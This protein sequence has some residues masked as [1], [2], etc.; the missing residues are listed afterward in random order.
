MIIE[1][2][3]PKDILALLLPVM[4]PLLQFAELLTVRT[5]EPL[6]NKVPPVIVRLP[7]DRL[8]ETV[9]VPLEMET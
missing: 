2:L 3:A 4:V 6:N 9:T 8:L 7:T 1:Q 5:L